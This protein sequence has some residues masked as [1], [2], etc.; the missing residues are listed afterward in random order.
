VSI[1]RLQH[2]GVA[3]ADHD[4]AVF[5]LER[6][7]LPSRDFRN[8]Q[9]KGFQHDSR[10]PLGNECWLHIV[11][12]WNPES[13]VNRFLDKHGEG[14]EHLALESDDIEADVARVRDADVPIFEDRIFDANDGFEA[15]I[16]PED[17]IGFTVELIEPHARSWNYPDD[18]LDLPISARLGKIRAQH[19]SA[20]VRDVAEA[21]RRF[22]TLFAT[23]SGNTPGTIALGNV[24]LR[25][26][27]SADHEPGLKNL[28]LETEKGATGAHELSF[29]VLETRAKEGEV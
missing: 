9:G 18:A 16:Y 12:N 5:G 24:E 1:L 2:I 27:A 22:T 7:G 3:L 15:F 6:V 11:H 26:Q 17:G 8:D 4:L 20:Y 23:P 13:R 19:V 28:V 21:S 25:L 10:V 29:L 14:L